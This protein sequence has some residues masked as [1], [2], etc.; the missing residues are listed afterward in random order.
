VLSR[1]ATPKVL[2]F[3]DIPEFRRGL[4]EC[5]PDAAHLS[6]QEL[7][8]RFREEVRAAELAHSFPVDVGD[9]WAQDITVKLAEKYPWFLSEYAA[10]MANGDTLS[11]VSELYN[12]AEEKFF[13][14]QPFA[15]ATTPT[16]KEANE[17]LLYIAQNLRQLD[18]GSLPTFGEVA[19]I[20][21]NEYV[22]DM[23]AI[24]PVDTGLY[25]MSCL[26]PKPM[27][28][29]KFACKK[30]DGS[31]GTYDYFDH[32]IL[33]NFE[34]FTNHSNTTVIQEALSLFKRSAFAGKYTSIQN[35][36]GDDGTR[37]Y[38]ANILGNPRFP[39]G[40]KFLVGNFPE[41]FGTSKM[42]EVQ[43]LANQ[44]SWPL[45]WALGNAGASEHSKATFRGN[46]RFL[47]P[48]V[49]A[50]GALNA[51]VAASSNS[52][53]WSV[54]RDVAMARSLTTP[55]TISQW[56]DWWAKLTLD[57]IQLAPLTA[58]SCS[59][60][61]HCVGTDVVTQECVCRRRSD[62]AQLVV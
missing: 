47:D 61:Q 45:V 36:S 51:T 39:D 55:P 21:S 48:T 13:A 53:F 8:E 46:Q 15:N 37:Y 58:R 5:C 34:V 6:S 59:K 1:A 2:A 30:W 33:P 7:L 10:P 60:P 42:L 26:S 3:F 57:Q 29:M 41:I 56:E 49:L 52:S 17:R 54:F 32:V 35:T 12:F 44:Y 62:I 23:V 20:F 50:T 14:L 28:N 18:T 27:F 31:V 40:V 43:R 19:A 4:Q 11:N 22:K 24:S 25:T 38:E 9:V 16:W